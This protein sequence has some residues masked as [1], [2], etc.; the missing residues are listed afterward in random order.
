M[1]S[2]D[3]IPRKFTIEGSGQMLEALAQAIELALR[4]ARTT[5]D[6]TG[7]GSVSR[8]PLTIEVEAIDSEPKRLRYVIASIDDAVSTAAGWAEA[9]RCDECEEPVALLFDDAYLETRNGDGVICCEC[10]RR[11]EDGEEDT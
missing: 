6:R 10:Y 8:G 4:A 3:T 1:S 2:S 9:K 11:I 5:P 7:L